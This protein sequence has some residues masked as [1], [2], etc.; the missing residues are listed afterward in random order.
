MKGLVIMA[1]EMIVEGE[2]CTGIFVEL[3]EDEFI[4]A[5]VVLYENVEIKVINP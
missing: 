1:G 2:E 4:N 5:E 3:S